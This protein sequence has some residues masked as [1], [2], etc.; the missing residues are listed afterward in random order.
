MIDRRTFIGT[1]LDAGVAATVANFLPL[2]S[3][4][5]AH[6]SPLPNPLPTELIPGGMDMNSVVFKIDG[7]DGCGDVTGDGP[8]I[9]DRVT[10]IPKSDHVWITISQSWRTAWR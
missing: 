2:S 4:L 7:W 6:R 8:K 10:N 5:Q 9:S 3:I 1:S